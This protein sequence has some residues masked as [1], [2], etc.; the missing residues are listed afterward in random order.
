MK[1]CPQCGRE[2]DTTMMFCLDDGT[3]LLYGPASDASP[4]AVFPRS[5]DSAALEGETRY[6]DHAGTDPSR[7]SGPAG[8][9]TGEIRKSKVPFVVGA[10]AITVILIG[11][12]A[13]TAYKYLGTVETADAFQDFQPHRMTTS[14]RAVEANISPDGKYVVY[15][16]MSDDGNRTLSI[17]Q[18]ATGDTIPIVPST[19]GNIIKGTTFSPDGNFVYYLFSDRTKG[20][21]LHQVSSLGGTPKKVLEACDGPVAFSP[22]GKKI[23]FTRNEGELDS[24]FSI[25]NSDGS[26]EQPLASLRVPEWFTQSGPSWSPDGSTIAITAGQLTEDGV[27]RFR[28]LAVDVASGSVTEISDMRWAEAGRVVWLPDG[29]SLI[30]MAAERPDEAG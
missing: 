20:T 3:E 28:L 25:A 26:G 21:S 9:A 19:R 16:D 29:N 17:R 24:K 2:Y 10:A 14:G 22:D 4:T 18:T 6:F 15:L 8:A 27:M 1:R 7:H 11:A 23:A 12:A 5:G 13:F 30:L